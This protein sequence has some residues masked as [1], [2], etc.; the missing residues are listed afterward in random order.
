MQDI[1]C[2]TCV[3]DNGFSTHHGLFAIKSDT[4]E[5]AIEKAKQ[6]VRTMGN[7]YYLKSVILI[8]NFSKDKNDIYMF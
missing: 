3:I 1:W 4:R 7:D 6:E 2:L 8:E 5:E